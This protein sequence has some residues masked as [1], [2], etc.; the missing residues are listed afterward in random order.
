MTSNAKQFVCV[1][2]FFLQTTVFLPDLVG[3]R[4]QSTEDI[5]EEGATRLAIYI[6]AVASFPELL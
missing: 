2:L 6:M 4:F 5:V 1:P 3:G